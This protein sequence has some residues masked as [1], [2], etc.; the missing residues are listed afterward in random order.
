MIQ[1]QNNLFWFKLNGLLRYLIVHVGCNN[2]LGYYLVNEYPKS[3]GSWL[4]QMLAEAVG[5]S[6]PRN[7][8]P[9]LKPSIMHGHYFATWNI[10]KAVVIWRDGRDVLI[11]QYYHYLFKNE[12]GNA[13]G[14]DIA[15]SDL[16]FL[17]Y[18]DIKNNLPKFMKHVYET[19][20]H[21]KFSWSE[22]VNKWAELEGAVNVKY[23]DLRLN[24]STELQKIAKKLNGIKL[25]DA[26]AQK[27]ADEY[28]FES[29]AKR[30]AGE[31]NINSFMRKGIVGDWKNYF[32]QESK[33]LFAKYAGDE[34]I[35]LGYEK[36]F[37]WVKDDN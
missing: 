29:Q 28:S 9:L 20:K 21:P 23:E 18:N 24:T 10:K 3:G 13:Y 34:L 12:R 25:S 27:I 2:S 26:K 17:D 35:T 14:V 1:Q 5:I 37:S 16:D 4:G 33:E 19:K 15:R 11:S 31:E 8:L 22:F 36:D 7:R 6:F 30:K 32:T